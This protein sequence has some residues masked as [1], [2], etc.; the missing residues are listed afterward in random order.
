MR[1][2]ILKKIIKQKTKHFATYYIRTELYEEKI[3]SITYSKMLK[4]SIHKTLHI[5]HPKTQFQ[6][7][8]G[9]IHQFLHHVWTNMYKND[10]CTIV[11]LSFLPVATAPPPSPPLWSLILSLECTWPT[12]CTIS[13]QMQSKI[14]L[15]LCVLYR[16]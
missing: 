7:P 3:N 12:L 2:N 9:T 1:N 10:C 6:F 14:K 5:F 15:M 8:M 16:A 13:L 4:Y 11:I